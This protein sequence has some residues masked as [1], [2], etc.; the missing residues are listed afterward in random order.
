MSMRLG[1]FIGVALLACVAGAKGWVLTQMGTD[2]AVLPYASLYVTVRMLW[3]PLTF[4]LSAMQSSLMALKVI[5]APL[6]VCICRIH[7]IG[8]RFDVGTRPFASL[9]AFERVRF[10]LF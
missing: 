3:L 9:L 10:R 2:A 5:P 7:G 4:V 8:V 6:H 1:A